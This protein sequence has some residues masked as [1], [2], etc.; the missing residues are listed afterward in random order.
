MNL[1]NS[2]D[3]PEHVIVFGGSGGIGAA[4]V[5]ELAECGVPYISVVYGRNRDA[6]EALQ[7]ELSAFKGSTV[8][9]FASPDRMNPQVVSEFLEQ[10]QQR[11]NLPIGGMVDAVGISENIPLEDQLV[12][13]WQKFLEV[14]VIGSF[15]V[16]RAMADYMTHMLGHAHRS[17]V[18]ITSTNGV[19]SQAS[20]S[21]HYDAT[22][23]AQISMFHN[24][25]E[26][27]AKEGV[28]VNAVAP[29]WVRT[30]DAML[31]TKEDM[32]KEIAK[33]WVGRFATPAEIAKPVRFLLSSDASYIVGQNIMVDGGY[34]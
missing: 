4:V 27:Y 21:A 33:I 8:Q 9:I 1:N 34:R 20:Y 5:R 13:E 29:G 32:D 17:I 14:N 2:N 6:A 26:G 22:K 18:L 15:V 31:P 25:A 10:V 16:L 3:L 7:A 24:L 30:T 19:N 12:S 23:A 28:R 11:V